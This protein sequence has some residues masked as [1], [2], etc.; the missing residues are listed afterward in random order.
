MFTPS[1]APNAGLQGEDVNLLSALF[2]TLIRTNVYYWHGF[3]RYIID[4][5]IYLCISMRGYYNLWEAF[6]FRKSQKAQKIDVE[7]PEIP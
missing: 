3:Y 6:S 5:S 4:I 2:F 1:L 7:L